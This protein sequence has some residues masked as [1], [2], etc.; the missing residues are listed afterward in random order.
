MVAWPSRK[1]LEAR[2]LHTSLWYRIPKLHPLIAK[3]CYQL[4][5][6]YSLSPYVT[7]VTCFF[8]V[9]NH[10]AH[11]PSLQWTNRLLW[12]MLLESFGFF[13]KQK[14]Q[15]SRAA[16]SGCPPQVTDS[17]A[18]CHSPS[19]WLWLASHQTWVWEEFWAAVSVV[20]PLVSKNKNSHFIWL[21]LKDNQSTRT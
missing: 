11:L 20:S 8:S 17:A 12:L 6:M 16:H 2:G 10:Q 7:R 18:E 14:V 9:L 21:L 3:L 5:C 4:L 19:Q 15:E 13:F 1:W